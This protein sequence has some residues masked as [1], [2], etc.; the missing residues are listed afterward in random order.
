MFKQQDNFVVMDEGM[1]Q[2]LRALTEKPIGAYP[3]RLI[4]PKG[5]T[6]DSIAALASSITS[7][8]TS[9]RDAL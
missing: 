4:I 2:E 8:L 3:N 1:G 6:L 9:K 5:W 7:S